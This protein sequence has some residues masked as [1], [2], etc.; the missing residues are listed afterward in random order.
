MQFDL[1]DGVGLIYLLEDLSNRPMTHFAP[2]GSGAGGAYFKKC[3]S[4]EQVAL[5]DAPTA[6]S[7]ARETPDGAHRRRITTAHTDGAHRRRT[8]QLTGTYVAYRC[9][10][11][12]E[13][14]RRLLKYARQS[15]VS[16]NAYPEEIYSGDLART[17]E[18][19]YTICEAFLINTVYE[20][21]YSPQSPAH[22]HARA[23]ACVCSQVR[24]RGGPTRVVPAAEPRV[25]THMHA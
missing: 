7:R 2:S 15:A 19:T 14:L 11:C 10:Q 5:C 22:A 4:R 16:T 6:C 20:G 3:D 17:R 1:R 21:S 23:H 24:R 18:L 25:C 13:N 9:A 12:L 8:L